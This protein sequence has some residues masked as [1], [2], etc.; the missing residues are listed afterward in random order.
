MKEFFKSTSMNL[1]T[2][3][4]LELQ[5]GEKILRNLDK[6]LKTRKHNHQQIGRLLTMRHYVSTQVLRQSN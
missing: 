2:E 3:E 6:Q 4:Q 1:M 5:C